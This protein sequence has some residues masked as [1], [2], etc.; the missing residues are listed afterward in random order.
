MNLNVILDQQQKDQNENPD[1]TPPLTLPQQI[2]KPCTCL[3]ANDACHQSNNTARDTAGQTSGA[4]GDQNNRLSR[5]MQVMHINPLPSL[6][7]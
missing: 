3:E 2:C 4:T 7:T 6:F 1:D 5:V